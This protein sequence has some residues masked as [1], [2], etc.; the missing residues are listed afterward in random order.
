VFI[1][2]PRS[3][4]TL[5]IN[6]I[7]S[8]IRGIIAASR[9]VLVKYNIERAKLKD[10]TKITPGRRAPTLSPLEDDHF[11]AVEAMILAS[12]TASTLDRLE[13]VGATDI[14]VFSFSNCRV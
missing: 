4:H 11:V 10:C 13:Q 14:L 7:V 12:E 3:K 1:K 9:H 6:Q 5:L 2:N 8:R